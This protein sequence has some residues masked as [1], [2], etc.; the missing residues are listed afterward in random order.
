MALSNDL[1]QGSVNRHIIQF[2][3]PLLISN[4]LQALYNAVDMYFAGKYL[5]TA[6]LSAVSMGGPVMNVL[7]M[8]IS[9][10]GVGVSVNIAALLGRG[11]E[12]GIRGMAGTAISVYAMAAVCI[13][14]LGAGFA[15]SL[16]RL[17]ATPPE[18]FAMA[19]TYL[20]IIFFGVLFTLGYNL[21][22]A[23]QRGFGDSRS[24][25]L[26]VGIATCTNAA[27]DYIL[28]G[29]FHM[30]VRGAALATITSQALSFVLGLL[31]FRARGHIVS[32]A[33]R[34]W[35][36]QKKALKD[37]TRVG[38]PSALQQLQLHVSHLTLNGIVNTYG[39]VASAAYGIGVKLD[40]FAVLPSMAVNDAVAS[41][42]SQNLG[43][44]KEDRARS[45]VRAGMKITVSFNL[46]LMI[47]VFL[48]AP[49][50]AH[51]FK[52][53][54]PVV[55]AA[56]DYLRI[57]CFMFV[58]YA[59]VHPMQG[60]IRGTGDTIFTLKNG[61]MAQYLIRIPI[62]LLLSK[63]LGLG[64][65]GVA[66]AWISAPLFSCMTYYAYMRA[67]SWRKSYDKNRDKNAEKKAVPTVH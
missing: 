13:T 16:L 42:T 39:V 17:V 36:L 62:A 29:R 15:P 38:L 44:K 58:L 33:P 35:R 55:V 59:I 60:F 18:A 37:L 24:S 30:G 8:T 32:F 20:R 26:F 23:I 48:F 3:Y 40:S 11:D 67:E 49:R 25:L 51:L 66:L 5:G 14:A 10:M 64:L 27:L 57:T 6:G 54:E 22:C 53:A 21:I 19:V 41:F 9:G 28:M 4:L 52:A 61:L 63:G 43:A 50:F 2:S 45:G 1:T 31:Y 34:A 7:L 47:A 12:E 56:A 65:A 46:L